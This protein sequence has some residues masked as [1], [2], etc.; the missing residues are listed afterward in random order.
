MLKISILHARVA[1]SMALYEPM[2]LDEH[3][4][5]RDITEDRDQMEVRAVLRVLAFPP[6]AHA[7]AHRPP[8]ARRA[9]ARV[10]A[11]CRA[12]PPADSCS[13]GAIRK[14]GNG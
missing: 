10:P 7:S 12:A 8:C 3:A 6:G 11:A 14:R 5:D 2:A 4:E 9:T 13:L 1:R